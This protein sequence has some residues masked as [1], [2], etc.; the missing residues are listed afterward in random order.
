MISSS[1]RV[2]SWLPWTL[3]ALLAPAMTSNGEVLRVGVAQVDVT[4]SYPTRL[5]GYGFRRAES[6]GVTHP[7]WVK[8]LAFGDEAEG[9]AILITSDNLGIPDAMVGRLAE[10]LAR[11]V[12]VKRERLTVTATHTHTAPM[13]N[14]LA[15]TIFG[16]PVPPDHQA[17]LDR[18]TKEFEEKLET[19]ALAAV[20]D[21]RPATLEW[22]LGAARFAANRRTP[23]GPVDHDMPMLVVRDPEGRPRAIYASYACHCVTLSHNQI[24]GDWAGFA[25]IAIQRDFPGAVA[26]LSV[27]C[28]ADSN[29][30]SMG[31]GSDVELCARQGQAIADEVK[32]LMSKPLSALTHKPRTRY[33]RIA[34]PFD[35]PRNREEWE[36]RAKRADAVGHQARVTLAKLDRGERLETEISYPVQS[37]IFGDQL[38]M[39][40]LS[41]EVV[42]DYSLRLKKELDRSRIWVLGYSND[43]PCYIP[44]E[45]VL[46]EGGYE[47][48]DAMI[49]YDRPQKFAPGLEQKIIDAARAQIPEAFTP[50]RGTEGTSPK[51]AQESLRSIRVPPG[52]SVELVASE[53]EVIDPV[54]IDW[55]AA[56]R[57]WVCEMRDYPTGI[58]EKWGPG[59]RVRVLE[60]KDGDGRY[61]TSTVFADGLPF[62]TGVMAWGKGALICAAPDVLYAEDLDGDGKADRIEKAF[63]GFFT[64]N[65]QARVNGLSLGLDHWVYGANGLLG[66][67]IQSASGGGLAV[68]IRGKDFRF[69]FDRS[70]FE[71]VAGLSQQGRVRDDWG[72]WFGCDN[73]TLLREYPFPANAARRNPHVALPDESHYVPDYPNSSR[74]FPISRLLERFNDPDNANRATSACGVG[75]YR[76][77]LLGESFYGNAFTCEPVHNLVHREVLESDGTQFTSR[78]APSELESEFLASSDN[79]FRPVQVRGGPDGAL[80]VVD[81]YRFLIEH[82]RWI[83]PSRLAKID[84]RAGSDRGRIYRVVATGKPKRPIRDLTRLTPQELAAALDNPSGAERDRVH[85]ALLTRADGAAALPELR[86][87]SQSAS[88]PQVRAQ[89]LWLAQR[90]TPKESWASLLQTA[91]RDP[92][93]RVRQAA[94]ECAEEWLRVDAKPETATLAALASLSRDSD[95][96]VRWRLAIAL[97]WTDPQKSPQWASLAGELG[98]LAR[99]DAWIRGAVLSSAAPWI[100]ELLPSALTADLLDENERAFAEG[101]FSTAL[102][103][104]TADQDALVSE[105]LAVD[106]RIRPLTALFVIKQTLRSRSELPLS[107]AVWEEQR[108]AFHRMATR[109]ASMLDQGRRDAVDSRQSET[110]REMALLTLAAVRERVDQDAEILCDLLVSPPSERL[111]RA[112]WT[113]LRSCN[114]PRVALR[115]LQ[116]WG[117][118]TPGARQQA[119][120]TLLA[121]ESGTQALLQAMESH[122]VERFDLSLADRHRLEKHPNPE[123]RAQAARLLGAPAASPRPEAMARFAPAANLVGQP[124]EGAALFAK[125]CA[126]CHALG[127][128]GFAVGPDLLPLKSKPVEYF[129]LNIVD[130]NAAIEPRYIAYEAELRDGRSLAG[131]VRSESGGRLTLALSGGQT[132]TVTTSDLISLRALKVSMMPEGLEQTLTVQGMADLIAFLKSGGEAKPPNP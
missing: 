9:P 106:Q 88:L 30:N 79:W 11:G 71:T 3:C 60:D 80:Y 123:I 83:E 19:V 119:T 74:V 84:V 44:S 105:A 46:K 69:R 72:R 132:E 10:K 113:A 12:G 54:A 36:T 40:F 67:A 122:Q 129:V 7:I 26:L 120:A 91:I 52:F 94:V 100:R 34:L 101:V 89:A 14:G 86:R 93:P 82:P 78:R 37:W 27:G 21:L 29:P 81:M 57:L 104:S 6:E 28:G 38:A 1:S 16:A 116:R 35:A 23:G 90:A 117:R 126:S 125:N 109:F 110:A 111:G 76:D 108:P 98:G 131:I 87:I 127:G 47:G 31:S 55:D 8:A 130:P 18:Y 114:D 102:H 73:G 50:V 99:K 65:Y 15:P 61:E 43:D 115:L 51:S 2:P 118:Y 4:P 62:P 112:A 107:L 17:H 24:G 33:Q 103:G 42:V 41:G 45:R 48:G 22:G 85:L 5:H 56:G 20:K 64:D 63:T 32:R 92:H 53:P 68:D 13:L 121:R 58:D 39:V 59:G 66:G 49:Y 97:G 77:T 70:G 25:Q 96:G 95:P 128:Q 75:L 124:Q